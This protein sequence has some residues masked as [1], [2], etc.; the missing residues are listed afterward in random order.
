ML[1]TVPLPIFSPASTAAVAARATTT[2]FG[3]SHVCCVRQ[4]ECRGVELLLRQHRLTNSMAVST[5]T[6]SWRGFVDLLQ[7]AWIGHLLLHAD[8]R[9]IASFAFRT[10]RLLAV[11]TWILFAAC[12]LGLDSFG[13]RGIATLSVIKTLLLHSSA[14]CCVMVHYCARFSRYHGEYTHQRKATG[15][16]S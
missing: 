14:C 11:R 12:S 5:D 3:M 2:V 4:Q 6:R 8:K 13:T 1:R 7:F 15:D 10:L 16:D 9:L